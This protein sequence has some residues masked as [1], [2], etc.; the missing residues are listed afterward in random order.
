MQRKATPAPAPSTT[1]TWLTRER[2]LVLVLALAT[3]LVAYLVWRLVQPFV[4]PITWAIVLAVL[5][6]PMHE[7]LKRHV[8]WPSVAAGLAVVIVTLVIAL[9]ATFV[10]RQAGAE[11]IESV[12]TVRNLMSGDRW[13]ILIER[14]PRAAGFKAWVEREVDLDEAAQKAGSEVAKGVRGT[15]ERTVN[16]AMAAVVTL[17][18]LFFFLRDK[19]WLLRVVRRL[20]PL[21][22]TEAEQVRARVRDTITAIV[23]GSLVVSVVQGTLGGI[24]FWW[25]GLPSPL[26][27][28]VVMGL[29]AMLPMFGTALVW[30]PAAGFLALNGEWEKA[31]IL[32]GF[33]VAVISVVDNLL[34]PLLVKGT[35]RLHT[36]PVF[37]SVLGGLFAFGATGIVLGPVI[38]GVG[39]ALLDIWQR[40]MALGEIEEGVNDG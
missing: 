22:P 40:R 17:F 39:L 4:P 27:W 5:A 34:Y 18:M 11:A 23:F 28:G 3:I 1:E 15:L 2:V 24:I 33:G 16:T 36:V 31:A 35:L 12:T 14:F 10:V 26:L 19:A 20:L 7:R 21:A 30:V 38:L 13:K 8:R 37:I 9:P 6:H 32:M 29:L 25:L